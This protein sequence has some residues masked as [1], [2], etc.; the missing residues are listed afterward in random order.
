MNE[1]EIYDTIP[2]DFFGLLLLI[3]GAALTITLVTYG[4]KARRRARL[5]NPRKDHVYDSGRQH[6]HSL[7]Q[8]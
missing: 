4:R 7:P 2:W 6:R 3:F 8:E 5:T 1:M